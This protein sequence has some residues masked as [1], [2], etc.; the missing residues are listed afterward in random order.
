MDAVGEGSGESQEG[1]DM[2]TKGR[3]NKKKEKR[4]QKKRG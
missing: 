4:R 3:H 1:K 2:S